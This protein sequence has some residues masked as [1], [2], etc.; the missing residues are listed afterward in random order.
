MAATQLSHCLYVE[1][2]LNARDSARYLESCATRHFLDRV[3]SFIVVSDAFRGLEATDHTIFDCI[4]VQKLLPNL[5]G[6]EMLRV[7]RTA[8]YRN[9][10]VLVVDDSDTVSVAEAV[11]LG[12]VGLLRKPFSSIQ[13]CETILA[14]TQF[15]SE[16][17]T[18]TVSAADSSS[19]MVHE[20]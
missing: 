6:I 8:G 18:Q 1:G 7:L 17:L 20:V 12:F 13:L 15:N 5:N 11:S 16:L 10:V 4:F 3:F 9:A 14:A 19:L 2:G